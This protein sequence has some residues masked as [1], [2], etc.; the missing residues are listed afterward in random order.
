MVNNFIITTKV[1]VL[2]A[3][4]MKAVRAGGHNLI[5]FVLLYP[6][7]LFKGVGLFKVVP[8]L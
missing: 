8:P 5:K 6:R 1:F 4:G 2:V 7:V 3:Q